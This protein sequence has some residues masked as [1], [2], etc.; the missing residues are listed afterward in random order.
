[1]EIF[2]KIMEVNVADYSPELDVSFIMFEARS[3]SRNPIVVVN[4]WIVLA[5]LVIQYSLSSKYSRKEEKT[6]T[7]REVVYYGYIIVKYLTKT[8][9]A[10]QRKS[11]KLSSPPAQ[12]PP[13]LAPSLL[14]VLTPCCCCCWS[15]VGVV[16]EVGEGVNTFFDVF[17]R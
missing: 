2:Y 15:G 8:A 12:P 11:W 14:E 6:G 1:M 4:N 3:C 7:Q 9:P 16:L 5:F 10:N 17:Q 13:R